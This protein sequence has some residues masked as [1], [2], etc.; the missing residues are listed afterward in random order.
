MDEYGHFLEQRRSEINQEKT[1]P[2][3]QGM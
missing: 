2:V 1:W 3:G